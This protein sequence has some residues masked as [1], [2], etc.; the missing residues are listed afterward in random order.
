MKECISGVAF[1][2]V[3]VSIFFGFAPS[4]AGKNTL[5]DPQRSRPFTGKLLHV[6]SRG[7]K[8]TISAGEKGASVLEE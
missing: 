7:E 1:A 2:D 5:V 8:F 3:V 6:S 4:P